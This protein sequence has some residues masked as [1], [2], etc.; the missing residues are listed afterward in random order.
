M[1]LV[2]PNDISHYVVTILIKRQSDVEAVIPS[3]WFDPTDLLDD[4][5]GGHLQGSAKEDGSYLCVS[6]LHSPLNSHP[7]SN[8]ECHND[9]KQLRYQLTKRGRC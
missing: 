6:P 2:C 9:D 8:N 4:G 7:K 1:F 3:G 5:G